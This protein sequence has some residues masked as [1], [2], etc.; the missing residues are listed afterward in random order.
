MFAAVCIR[1]KP[2]EPI[3]K[4]PQNTRNT[5]LFHANRAVAIGQSRKSTRSANNDNKAARSEVTKTHR[6][7][8]KTERKKNQKG[9]IEIFE[10]PISND[11]NRQEPLSK[12]RE[13]LKLSKAQ[14]T[15][16]CQKENPVVSREKERGKEGIRFLAKRNFLTW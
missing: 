3:S 2:P 16:T 5:R 8:R 9:Q 15:R 13:S 6:L 11:T 14:P 4:V 10:L 1:D 12:Y 7:R